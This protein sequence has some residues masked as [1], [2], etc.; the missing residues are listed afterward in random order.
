MLLQ[1][2]VLHNKKL[3]D[4]AKRTKA[5]DSSQHSLQHKNEAHGYL[6]SSQY[7]DSEKYRRA[8]DEYLKR[9]DREFGEHIMVGGS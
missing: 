2:T 3:A 9:K 6:N 5:M 4:D 8:T 1:R 7:K